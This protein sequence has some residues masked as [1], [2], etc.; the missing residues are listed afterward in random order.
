MLAGMPPTAAQTDKRCCA[1]TGH[2]ISG[3]IRAY[4]E[5]NGGLPVFGYP[6]TAQRVETVEDRTIPV[7]WFERDRIE[8]QADG[9]ITAGRLG[10][11]VLELRWR[12]WF[13]ITDAPIPSPECRS[14]P[15]TG[16]Y[17]CGEFLSYWE[18]NGGLER[19]AMSAIVGG[20]EVALHS[21]L[22]A[23]SIVMTDNLA[24]IAATAIDRVI[25]TLPT[26]AID[27]AL[28]HTLGL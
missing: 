5:R 24:A 22:L 12:P 9:T 4:W 11:R 7:Q 16:Y 17:V 27:I 14:F 25:G 8:I 13:P 3:P 1:E 15:A 18:R 26:K 10:A 6:I 28:R 23:D 21:G 20:S 2:C 19:I